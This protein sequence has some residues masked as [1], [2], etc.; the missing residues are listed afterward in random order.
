MVLLTLGISIS[1]FAQSSSLS[2]FEEMWIISPEFK[3]TD[4]KASVSLAPESMTVQQFNSIKSFNDLNKIIA[5]TPFLSLRLTPVH[6]KLGNKSKELKSPMISLGD[7][8]QPGKKYKGWGSFLVV[9]QS[10]KEIVLGIPTHEPEKLKKYF[11]ANKFLITDKMG[12]FNNL[13]IKEIRIEN[14][15]YGKTK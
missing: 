13:E 9:F 3:H 10:G 7:R 8:Y 14:G 2:T 11:E 5:D 1:G 15:T 12:K 4:I 6:S